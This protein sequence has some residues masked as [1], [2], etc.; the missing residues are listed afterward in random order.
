M[1]MRKTIIVIVCTII[2]RQKVQCLKST[3]EQTCIVVFPQTGACPKFLWVNCSYSKG[4]LAF[5]TVAPFSGA[6]SSPRQLSPVGC[7]VDSSDDCRHNDDEADSDV[8]A[9]EQSGR[10]E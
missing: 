10:G 3:E 5:C 4:T 7:A 9:L 6:L 8:D 1:F 2:L